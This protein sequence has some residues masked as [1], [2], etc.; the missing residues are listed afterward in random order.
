MAGRG[1]PKG[2]PKTPGSGRRRGSLN[3]VTLAHKAALQQMKV[4]RSDPLSF[5]MSVLRN[6]DAP[7]E[8]AKAAA[9]ELLPYTN[10]KLAS[11]E[12]RSGGQTHEARLALYHQLLS[13]DDEPLA[14]RDART[15]ANGE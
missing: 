11:I 6:P 13:D 2:S 14:L 12:A 7:Y 5:F 1:R 15:L 8:E 9:R 10:P 3:K 4:D